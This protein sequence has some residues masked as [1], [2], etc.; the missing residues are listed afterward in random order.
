[1]EMGS[2][3]RQLLPAAKQVLPLTHEKVPGYRRATYAFRVRDM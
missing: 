1:M 2:P 3:V